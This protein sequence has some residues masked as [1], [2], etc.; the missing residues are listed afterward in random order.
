MERELR[1]LIANGRRV[2]HFTRPRWWRNLR[3]RFRDDLR[4]GFKGKDVKESD[5]GEDYLLWKVYE[6]DIAK[7]NLHM[8]FRPIGIVNVEII[9]L[10]MGEAIIAKTG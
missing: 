1:G 3:R 9:P 2:Y 7:G 10:L 8:L 4:G 5:F 6:V